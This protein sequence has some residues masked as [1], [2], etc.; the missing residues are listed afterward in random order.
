MMAF[1]IK[2]LKDWFRVAVVARFVNWQIC[3]LVNFVRF[4][5]VVFGFFKS[6]CELL[7][8]GSVFQRAFYGGDKCRNSRLAS[9]VQS[10]P[11]WK[12]TEAAVH[13]RLESIY[14]GAIV[15]CEDNSSFVRVLI[16]S[17]YD[18]LQPHHLLRLKED[19]VPSP[20]PVAC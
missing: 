13:S 19:A 11:H 5:I 8:H 2:P 4:L 7:C 20:H 17:S 12:N 10:A 3:E 15:C 1:S 9:A 16:S 6:C 14:K 18:S